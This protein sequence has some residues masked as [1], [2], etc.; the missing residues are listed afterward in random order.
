MARV[1][2]SNQQ[3]KG[4][5]LPGDASQSAYYGKSTKGDKSKKMTKKSKR[6]Y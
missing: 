1:R 2:Q 3:K 4:S 6:G 5:Q